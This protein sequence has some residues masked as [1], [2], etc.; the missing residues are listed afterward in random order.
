MVHSERYFFRVLA[1]EYSVRVMGLVIFLPH[2]NASNVVL[3]ILK[4]DKIWGTIRISVPHP[5]YGE[6]RPPSL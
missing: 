4:H 3:D 1:S 2:C 6:T 5:N